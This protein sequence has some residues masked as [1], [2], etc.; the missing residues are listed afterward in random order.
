[1]NIDI[2]SDMGEINQLLADGTYEKMMDHVDSINIACGAHAGDEVMMATMVTMGSS[3]KI[4]LG[5][6]PGFR[7]KDNF[8]RI[9]MEI[10]I[11][12]LQ[13]DI[14][15]QIQLLTDICL[16]HDVNIAHVKPHGALYNKAA[17]DEDISLAIGEAILQVD[18]SLVAVGLAESKMLSVFEGLGLATLAEAFV[19]RL[20]EPNGTLRD[21]KFEDALISDPLKASNQA[22][23]LLEGYV[24]SY[25]GSRVEIEA[26]TLCVHS[27]TTNAIQIAEAVKNV[28]Q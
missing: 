28:V 5:A 22:K 21:R 26:Q 14:R 2:N 17:N 11:N 23:T 7:D 24:R 12:E 25:D 1:M 9:D 13:D 18:P 10:D 3:K 19:D 15:D 8:G 16:E 27:D 20:Y 4:K 6:H